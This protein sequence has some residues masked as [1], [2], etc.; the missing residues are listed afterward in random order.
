[1]IVVIFA[2]LGRT[3]YDFFY[4]AHSGHRGTS[5]SLIQGTTF[6][7]WFLRLTGSLGNWFINFSNLTMNLL[8]SMVRT[9]TLLALSSLKKNWIVIKIHCG[10]QSP[11][12]LRRQL[13]NLHFFQNCGHSQYNISWNYEIKTISKEKRIVQ[14]GS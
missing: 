7:S 3:F 4:L 5:F 6:C 11:F 10:C 8:I 9:S 1:M 14:L 2:I 13:R 12:I